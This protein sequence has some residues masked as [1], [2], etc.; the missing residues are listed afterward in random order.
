MQLNDF[1]NCFKDLLFNAEP[2]P[3]AQNARDNFASLVQTGNI[4]LNERLSIYR[5]NVIGSLSDIMKSNFPLIENLVG[6]DFMTGM[7]RKFIIEGPPEDGCLN[8]YGAGFAD[9]I[10]AFA[11]AASLPYLPDVARFE[12]ARHAAYYARDDSALKAKKLAS[13]APRELENIK[14]RLRDSVAL[15]TSPYPLTAIREFCGAEDKGDDMLDLDQGGVHLLIH[16]PALKV[17]VLEINEATF[18]MLRN[19]EQNMPLGQAVEDVINTHEG[20]DFQAFL[21]SQIQLETFLCLRAN[22]SIEE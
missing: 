11:P 10:A 19:F 21:Q 8:D 7:A 17:E 5:G 13:I 2:E 12:W 3:G 14:L 15:I 9:F 18:A 4:P 1:Q 22:I 16:R 6:E 20:F